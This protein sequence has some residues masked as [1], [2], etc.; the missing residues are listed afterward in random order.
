MKAG[1]AAMLVAARAF[2]KKLEGTPGI[3]LVLTAGRRVA[4]SARR[5]SLPSRR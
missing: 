4:A 3:T 1:V 2:G 5:S